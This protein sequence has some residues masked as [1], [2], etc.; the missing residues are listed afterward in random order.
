MK[1]LRVFLVLLLLGFPALLAA[2]LVALDT[3]AVDAYLTRAL[4][5]WA[6]EAGYQLSLADLDLEPWS[7][8][9]TLGGVE[10]QQALGGGD[11]GWGLTAQRV[12]VRLRFLKSL[13]GTPH[14][15]LTL[16]G[17][18]VSGT[19]PGTRGNDDG[20][21]GEG[22]PQVVLH[23]LQVSDGSVQ[24]R[25]PGRGL[26]LSV[27]S[28][29][30]DWVQDAGGGSARDVRVRWGGGE[31]R[32]DRVEFSGARRFAT[33]S[34]DRLDLEGP[35]L[36][37][38]TQGRIGP[39]RLLGLEVEGD[40]HLDGL[41][42]AWLEALHLTR[43]A[44]LGGA[45]TLAGHLGGST[46]RPEFEG[47]L[48]L[49]D[50]R[51]GTVRDA[52]L[53]SEL[54]ADHDGLR[55]R[56]LR[57]TSNV[58]TVDELSGQ[59]RWDDGLWLQAR[60]KA[61]EYRLRPFMGILFPDDFFPVGLA[62]D[63]EFQVEGPLYPELA[64]TGQGEARVRDLDVTTGPEGQRRTHFALP[65]ARLRTRFTVGR[66]EITFG[67]SRVETESADMDISGGRIAYREGLWFSTVAEI[68][69]L[70]LARPLLP[71]WLDARGRAEGQFGGPYR[72]L[73]FIYD[74]DLPAVSLGGQLL[75]RLR[76]HG[77]FDLR[78][79]RVTDG[80]L[81]GP[82]GELFASGAV[83]LAPEGEHQWAVRWEQGD[84]AATAALLRDLGGSIPLELSGTV[85]S[86]GR[87]TGPLAEP[88][89]A[90]TAELTGLRI[91]RFQ[92][93]RAQLEGRASRAGWQV[94]RAK[95]EAYGVRATGVG[96]GG[97]SEFHATLEVAGLGPF[98]EQIDVPLPVDGVFGG[99]V[100]AGGSYP[101]AR[102]EVEGRVTSPSAYGT[103]L[104]DSDLTL[105]LDR[106]ALELSATA[107]GG[108]LDVLLRREFDG[109]ALTAQATA[110]EVPWAALPSRL[111]PPGLAGN[112]LSGTA[113][114]QAGSEGQ[115]T[116]RWEG[117]A[118]GI[119]WQELTVGEVE[120]EGQYGA[121]AVGFHAAA[122]DQSVQLDG[123]VS[124]E[125]GAPVE[126]ELALAGFSLPH[127]RP[128]LTVASGTADGSGRALL[129]WE[130]WRAAQGLK[131]ISAL[132]DLEL[133]ATV[134]GLRD[135]RGLELPDFQARV[136][137]PDG[138]PRWRVKSRGLELDG[139]VEDLDR[140]TWRTEARLD[141]FAPWPLL[142]PVVPVEDL[143]GRLSGAGW[144]RGAGQTVE[145]AEGSGRLE[146]LSWGGWGHSDWDW[147]LAYQ[148]ARLTAALREP[149]G[150]I[151]IAG[152]Q[153]STGLEA[154]LTL[155]EV[156][157]AGW[158]PEPGPAAD[159]TGVLEGRG[160]LRWPPEGQPRGDLELTEVVLRWPPLELASDAPARVRWDGEA[161]QLESFSMLGEGV[162]VAA[163]G[164]GPP[165]MPLC[166]G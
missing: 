47:T 31:E 101:A 41:P 131:R 11:D 77:E 144:L 89:Y 105:D 153:P 90:G 25:D 51:F 98:L 165:H 61:R 27:G 103:P 102:V 110:S 118:R 10:L 140:A 74:L 107:I 138:R 130:Q 20:G 94:P 93:G 123:L 111:L 33:L 154:D 109:G 100:Q 133:E 67:P 72:E 46:R 79:L 21:G 45:L 97:P 136:T 106:E 39:W 113:E 35:R 134:E 44:P 155:R 117:T 145:A 30:V 70:A 139:A 166:T 56:R 159:L 32:L 158:M 53:S 22:A 18:I 124:P 148:G 96:A 60:G 142:P 64:L 87:L 17:P 75:G 2:V 40:V 126:L 92:V 36:R 157:L 48:E 7:A 135:A 16:D 49:R 13:L 147:E 54:S 91:D 62:A 116:A 66:R 43:F 14:L 29:Q 137:S 42:G 65:A 19:L 99:Q 55:F 128:Y 73:E 161:V 1:R 146:A 141:Q 78:D 108:R 34:L 57:G 88:E 84:L 104:P 149:R 81:S 160:S 86:Q 80:H 50:G 9:L 8:R 125:V 71:T 152:W 38:R 143:R 3:T 162:R 127:L 23:T 95:L 4:P 156:P 83:T 24:L 15:E 6:G 69:S 28:V 150:V 115:L 132:A 5:R 112:S 151:L 68:R 119:S 58:V 164:T 120:F 37:L 129:G 59:L 26:E 122:W 76:G 63:G 85:A 52:Q 163:S 82:L 12:A 121:G 114:L